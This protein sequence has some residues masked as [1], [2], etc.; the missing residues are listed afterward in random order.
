MSEV[1]KFHSTT[2]F[3]SKF[4]GF[5]NFSKERSACPFFSLI[6]A[7]N[8]L[9]TGVV[10]NEQY[11]SNLIQGISAYISLRDRIPQ[12][13]TFEEILQFAIGHGSSFNTIYA[14]SAELVKEEIL[15]YREFF[16]EE[17]NGK[18]YCT[19][20]LKDGNFFVV[21]VDENSKYYLR[22]CHRDVQYNFEDLNGLRAH[23]NQEYRM[24]R[25]TVVDGYPIPEFNNI[26]FLV[27]SEKFTLLLE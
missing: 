18:R 22:D 23:L 12:F 20:F 5:G 7:Y 3:S 8:F 16:P 17:L 26:E 1:T 14:S 6:S 25:P 2:Q 9:D 19:I 27:V 4:T 21:L 24:D 10:S 11:E 15:G 13:L